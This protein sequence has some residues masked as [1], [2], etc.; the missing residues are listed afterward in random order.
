MERE[1]LFMLEG[2]F[3]KGIIL[4][5]NLNLQVNGV[6]I[7]Q[8]DREYIPM[9]MGIDMKEDGKMTSNL[10]EVL[11]HGPMARNIQVNIS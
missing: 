7:K 5:T 1:S 2:I 6:M 9:P 4:L 3:M 10:E 11:K 8:T